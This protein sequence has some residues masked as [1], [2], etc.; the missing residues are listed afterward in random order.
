MKNPFR[1]LLKLYKDLPIKIKLLLLLY[2]QITIPLVLIGFF[3]YKISENI[4][5]NK[6][7]SYSY[8]IMRIMDLRLKDCVNSL[9][10][11]SQD[12]LYDN[13]IYLSLKGEGKDLE[14]LDVY[15]KKKDIDNTLKKYIFSRSEIQSIYFESSDR[16]IKFYSDNNSKK[17][18]IKELINYEEMAGKAR[19]GNGKVKWYF[20]M[21]NGIAKNIFLVRTVNDR[22]TFKEIGLLVFL[23]DKE[24][25]ESVYKEIGTEDIRNMVIISSDNEFIVKKNPDNKY[26]TEKK[27]QSIGKEKEG[28]I[29]DHENKTLISYITMDGP[30]WKIISDIPLERLF[31]EVYSFRKLVIMLCII[32]ALLLT[33][34]NK[35]ISNDLV[36]PI[37]KLVDGMRQIQKGKYKDVEVDRYDEL[38]FISNTF[39]DMAKEITHLI[40][41]IYSEQIT[42]KDAQLKALQSQINPHFLFNTLESINWMAQLNNVPEI[43]ET[44]SALSSLME[45]GIGRDDKLITISEEFKYIDNYILILKKRFEDNIQIIFDVKSDEILNIQI[46]RL[47]I[48]PLIENSIYHGFE[49]SNKKGLIRLTAFIVGNNLVIEALDNGL[50]MD[51][52]ELKKLNENLSADNDTYFRGLVNS[53]RKSIGLEN[54]NRRIKLFYGESYGIIITSE[55]NIFTKVRVT[56]PVQ[57][58]DGIIRALTEKEIKNSK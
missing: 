3:S 33:L 42:R 22:D 11:V 36:N 5:Q 21:E 15:E 1:R 57:T 58:K 53:E 31:K 52:N 8:D 23:I 9:S 54:V 46:P 27:L 12:I 29:I 20:Q 28:C 17:V 55:K 30:E 32:T 16:K 39:N 14:R 37:K 13:N 43:S 6:S 4:I 44:V 38:G 51:E 34:L 2:I 35:Q 48:Q 24:F 40:T 45:A 18:A 49:N 56:I 19:S 41:G 47:L 10:N 50:G 7:I 26:L 25:I